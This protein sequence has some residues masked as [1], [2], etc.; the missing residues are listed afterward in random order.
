MLALLLLVLIVITSSPYLQYLRTFHYFPSS[1]LFN[2]S[3]ILMLHINVSVQYNVE[4]DNKSLYY[5][6]PESDFFPYIIC[7]QHR[8][9]LYNRN[10][11]KHTCLLLHYMTVET[12]NMDI[13][14]FYATASP[15]VQC[16]RLTPSKHRYSYV[17]PDICTPTT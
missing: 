16:C 11:R 9:V 6:I 4:R 17:S 5:M 3:A 15:P 7:S 12:Q 1:I 14:Q 10:G 13:S 2:L 8:S